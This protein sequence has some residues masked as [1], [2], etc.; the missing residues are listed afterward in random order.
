MKEVSEYI[1]IIE[2][3]HKT[4]LELFNE[5]IIRIGAL[6]EKIEKLEGKEEAE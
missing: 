6:E 2:K 5:L 3:R 1:D 4:Y